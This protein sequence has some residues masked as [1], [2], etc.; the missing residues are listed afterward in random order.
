MENEGEARRLESQALLPAYRLEEELHGLEMPPDACVLDAGCGTGLVARYIAE[1]Y[2][3][4]KV[5][6]CDLSALRLKC[7]PN[8]ADSAGEPRIRYFESS[9]EQIRAKEA[10]YDL[11]VCRYVL[12]HMADA[13]FAAKEFFRVLRPGG[14]VRV[15][16][17]DGIIYNL[18]PMSS[19]LA[20]MT[21]KVKQELG[22][23][24]YV[25]R[26]IPSYLAKAGFTDL[27]WKTM[28]VDFQGRDLES[29]R[30]NTIQRMT[31]AAPLLT[32]ILGSVEKASRFKDL[33]CA[34]MMKP[35]ATL[36]YNKF[37]VTG[38]K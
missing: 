17:F 6:G 18:F 4:A 31:F 3:R 29:E 22:T 11:V 32:K 16:D 2:R 19:E 8:F 34:E 36:F 37:V 10:S 38:K 5:E 7:A 24:L 13:S 21:E 25:G 20:E 27:S 30:E 9:L 33:Y 35:G 12:E 23:D 28:A 26:K 14:V 15:I 1:R